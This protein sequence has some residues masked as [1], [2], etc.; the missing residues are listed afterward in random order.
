M[1]RLPETYDL[2]YRVKLKEKNNANHKAYG[3]YTILIESPYH[4]QDPKELKK[5]SQKYLLKTWK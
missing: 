3:L 1:T 5:K 4:Y 2:G